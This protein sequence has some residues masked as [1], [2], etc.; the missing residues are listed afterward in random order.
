MS[1]APGAEWTDYNDAKEGQALAARPDASAWVAANAGSGKTKVLIDR[2]ARLLLMPNTKPDEILCVT[3]TKAAASEMQAR[4]FRTL[5]DWCVMDSDSLTAAL[6]KLE[7][8]N[9]ADYNIE[10]IGRARELFAQALETPGGLRI[11]TIH[12][13]C[14]RVLRRF[15]LEAGVAPGFQELDDAD[16]ADL[17]DQAFRTIGK[18]VARGDRKLVEAA[19]LAAEIGGGNGFAAL[20][21]LKSRTTDVQAFIAKACGL[22]PAVEALRRELGAGDDTVEVLL[23]RAMGEELPREDLRHLLQVLPGETKSDAGL[24]EAI[25]MA[26]SDAPSEERFSAYASACFT[27][28]GELRKANPYTKGAVSA[29]PSLP[30]LFQIKEL[31][32]GSEIGRLLALNEALNARRI[33]DRSA[34]MLRLAHVLFAD[35]SRRKEARAGLDFD[36]LIRTVGQLLTVQSAAEWVLWKLDGGITHILL[37]EAQDTSPNQWRILRALTEDIFTGSGAARKQTRTLFVVGDQKQSIYSFQG[38]D[39]EHFLRETLQFVSAADIAKENGAI[40]YFMPN[41][42]M[43]FRSA[44]EILGYVDA[45]FETSAFDGEAPFSIHPP[46]ETDALRHTPFRRD[47]CG[48]VEV[49]PLDMKAEAEPA[50]PWD[51]PRG[52]ESLASAKAKLAARIAEFIA[53][54]IDSGASIWDRGE[55]RPCRPGDFLILVGRRVGGLFDAVLQ[56]LKRKGIPVA[57]ADRIQLLDSLAVQDL[58]NL[59]RFALAPEEDL[60]LAEIIK[61]P[62]GGV[63]GEILD[64]AALFD[65]AYDR[66]QSLWACLQATTDARFAALKIFLEGVLARRHQ[67]PFEFLT[68]ALERGPRPGWQL[69]LSR[70][71]QPAR[72][73][74]TAL[75][76]RAAAF[77]ADSPPSLQLFLDA[78][79]RRGGEVKRELSGPQDEVRVMTVHG[80]KGLEAPIVILPD[81]TSAHR[82]DTHGVFMTKTG[83]PVWVGPKSGDIALTAAMRAEVEARALREHRRLLYVALTRARDRLVV[84]GAFQGRPGEAGRKKTSWY[85]VCESAMTRLVESGAATVVEEGE[86]EIFRLG[87]APEFLLRAQVTKAEIALPAWL[88]QPAPVEVSPSR[89]LSPSSLGG[90]EPPAIA[91]FGPGREARLRRGNLIH[92]MLEALPEIPPLSR[93]KAAKDFLKRQLELTPAQREEMLEAAFGVLDDPQFAAVFGPGGHAEAP[94]IGQI[95]TDILSGRVDRLV[96]TASEI[97]IVDYK[98]DR[99]AP[100]DVTG[101]GR[102]YVTQMAAYR[103][104]LSQAWPNRTIRC[105]LVWTDG[106]R[107]ME[108]PGSDL[109]Q[110]LQGVLG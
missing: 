67:A 15:P 60:P 3:Y 63:G 75:V 30:A 17:W 108:I 21:A 50:R 35:F 81:T 82:S 53:R 70:F 25:A 74:V 103:A 69:I 66:K 49:W 88:R 97:V 55:K 91:P 77:D 7:E 34:A 48:T 23:T 27:A 19:R 42:A 10:D 45:A 73:P 5:G 89:I 59:V 56:A 22:E 44:P 43:S 47:E 83:A 79:E 101:V 1:D 38:A 13:F 99:P 92:A 95:G 39:P 90:G 40:E 110:V 32:Q 28:A 29:A 12:A 54:E 98:T 9:P 24:R 78:V 71:G 41:L 80:A 76:D 6:A 85:A 107:L 31:P 11:E 100:A 26:L 2:V 61:G 37:D 8:R 86:R 94:V 93:R 52:Q 36:D 106:P 57:G 87:E 105:L 14:G 4:L 62:F 68:H 46:D 16:A 102:A 64:D 18:K 51:A 20:L 84:C 104:I 109:D 65:L 33:F 96:V 72:E 58:L